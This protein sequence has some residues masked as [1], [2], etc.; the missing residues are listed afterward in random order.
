MR[1][2]AY[3]LVDADEAAALVL[4]H[5]PVLGSSVWRSRDCVG[6]VLAEDL[7][8]P[9][10]LPAFPSSAVDGYAV[11][12]ADAGR[13]LRVA[14]RVGGRPAASTARSRPGPRRAS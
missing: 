3:P 12:A 9:R 11:R 10:S 8:A 6:R 7:V 1:V 5:T 4:E 14:R 13:T 2:S